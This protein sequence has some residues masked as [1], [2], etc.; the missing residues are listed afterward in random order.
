MKLFFFNLYFLHKCA[1]CSELQSINKS[2]SLSCFGPRIF[3]GHSV[4]HTFLSFVCCKFIHYKRLHIYGYNN[5]KRVHLIIIPI[6]YKYICIFTVQTSNLIL[7]ECKSLYRTDP[8]PFL[9]YSFLSLRLLQV[10]IRIKKIYFSVRFF[11]LIG[12]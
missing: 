10:S 12:C 6:V 3:F 2:G 5:D 4:Y 7:N 8:T 9:A 1:T 11:F